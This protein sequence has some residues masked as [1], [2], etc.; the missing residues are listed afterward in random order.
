[1]ISELWCFAFGG[2]H[3]CREG[4]Y[5]VCSSCGKRVKVTS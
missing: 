2:H 4:A 5:L 3:F 1:M